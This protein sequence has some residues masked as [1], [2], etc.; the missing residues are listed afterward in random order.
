MFAEEDGVQQIVQKGVGGLPQEGTTHSCPYDKGL[1]I[2]EVRVYGKPE[3]K[4]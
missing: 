4:P 1:N 2:Q 3:G